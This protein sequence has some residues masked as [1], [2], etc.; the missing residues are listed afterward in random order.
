MVSVLSIKLLFVNR[1]T[2]LTP[3]LK[4]LITTYS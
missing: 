1:E 3:N 4:I 2:A